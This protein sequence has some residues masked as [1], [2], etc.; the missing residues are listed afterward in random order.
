MMPDNLI[1][2]AMRAYFRR[3]KAAGGAIDQPA[4]HLC[5]VSTRG[6]VRLANGHRELARYRYDAKADRLAYV[7]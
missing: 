4:Q 5:T 3:G 7:G 6:M 2:R 1:D